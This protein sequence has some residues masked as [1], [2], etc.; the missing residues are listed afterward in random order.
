MQAQVM[1]FENH[2]M[3]PLPLSFV[4]SETTFTKVVQ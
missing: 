4:S 1:W 2:D 3:C